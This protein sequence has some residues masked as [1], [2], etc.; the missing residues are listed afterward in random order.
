MT[1]NDRAGFEWLKMFFF[2]Y[3][4][5]FH[6]KKCPLSPFLKIKE[7]P[8]CL[9]LWPS[10]FVKFLLHGAHFRVQSWH[11]TLELS[12]C[13]LGPSDCRVATCQAGRTAGWSRP[14]GSTGRGRSSAG[15]P[16][17]FVKCSAVQCSADI[18]VN[19]H[20]GHLAY[21]CKMTYALCIC[22]IAWSF[23]I[24]CIHLFYTYILLFL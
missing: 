10:H 22:K 5:L 12:D 24:K 15:D 18:E 3:T 23:C 20:H 4:V 17:V 2:K 7:L 21:I 14:W 11:C 9:P 19:L 6:N 8:I 1:I 16:V 13:R